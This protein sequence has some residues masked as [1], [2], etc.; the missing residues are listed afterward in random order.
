M[1]LE[2]SVFILPATSDIELEMQKASIY[3]MTSETECFPM[4]LLEAQASRLPIVSYNCP[5]GPRNIINNDTDGFLIENYNQKM[6]AEKLS[7]LIN[8]EVLLTK[9]QENATINLTK[10]KKDIVMKHWNDLFVK[11]TTINKK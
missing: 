2:N 11:M 1:N 8:S 5:N 3:A 7:D 4:V 9:M 10:F 6:F